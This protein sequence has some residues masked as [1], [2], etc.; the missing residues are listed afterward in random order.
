MKKFKLVRKFK[1]FGNKSDVTNTD[2]R[3]LVSGS[4]NVFI[5]DEDKIQTRPGYELDGP[6]ATDNNGIVSSYD[7]NTS[8]GVERNLRTYDDEIEYRYVDSAGDITWRKLA[9]GFTVNYSHHVAEWWD[10]SEA[11][12]ALLF[13]S[14]DSTLRSW[15]GGVTTFASATSN[16]ITKEGTETWAESRFIL[17]GTT[18]VVIDGITYT[19]TGGESTTTLTGVT[20]DPTAGGSSTLDVY[21][22]Y[23]IINL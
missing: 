7:W 17:G 4:Q 18:Q 21:I 20:G 11:E 12:D 6:T 2:R 22:S 19:Y 23:R 10:T 15:S 8:T 16:T 13:V 14:G 3:F 9:D 1:G 5:N